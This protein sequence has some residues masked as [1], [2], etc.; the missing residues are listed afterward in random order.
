[1]QTH[2]DMPVSYVQGCLHISKHKTCESIKC[3]RIGRRKGSAYLRLLHTE[4]Q[5]QV[6]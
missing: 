4:E 5:F 1:M 3:R 6:R 2:A